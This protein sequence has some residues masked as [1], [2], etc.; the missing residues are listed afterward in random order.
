MGKSALRIRKK[1]LMA[2]ATGMSP[3][4]EKQRFAKYFTTIRINWRPVAKSSYGVHQRLG[5]Q[6]NFTHHVL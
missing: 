3:A 5:S 4:T 2:S 1:T 6:A